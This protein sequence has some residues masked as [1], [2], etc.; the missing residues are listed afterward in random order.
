ML[1]YIAFVTL[2]SILFYITL[3]YNIA[4]FDPASSARG[5]GCGR[6]VRYSSLAGE[7]GKAGKAGKGEIDGFLQGLRLKIQGCLAEIAV[8]LR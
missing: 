2:Y 4:I 1:C 5:G 7:A 6:A 8:Y 3:Q